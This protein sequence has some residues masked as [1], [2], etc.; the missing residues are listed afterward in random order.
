MAGALLALPGCANLT[1]SSPTACGPVPMAARAPTTAAS[2]MP[3][4]SVTPSP[5]A[6]LLAY[7]QNLK[8]LAPAELAR[9]MTE[10]NA[11]PR[12]P[13]LALR[14]AMVLSMSR[15]GN[16]LALAQIHLDTVLSSTDPQAEALKPLARLLGTQWSEQRRL[17]E[18]LDKLNAQARDS[19]RKTEQLNEKLE[20]LKTI[21]RTLPAS[22]ATPGPAASASSAKQGG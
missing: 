5:V 11:Q 2:G 20:A 22:P 18:A 16:D 14:K 9:E 17:S 10:L 4:S 7:H 3:M 8:A 6:V 21:E 1:P 15:A 12:T 13:A 19:Q